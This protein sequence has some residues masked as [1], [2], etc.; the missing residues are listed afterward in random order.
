MAL[1]NNSIGTDK[2][3]VFQK[4]IL[5]HQSLS[6]KVHGVDAFEKNWEY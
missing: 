1:S 6:S 5:G 3:F 4:R 2:Y